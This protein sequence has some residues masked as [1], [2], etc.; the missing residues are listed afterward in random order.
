LIHTSAQISVSTPRIE[1]EEIGAPES[2]MM[3]ARCCAPEQADRQRRSRA[4]R[5]AEQRDRERLA[6]RLQISGSETRIG[7][8][9]TA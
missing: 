4:K 7:G 8:I 9:I 1:L 3:F 2:G 6:E 5:G